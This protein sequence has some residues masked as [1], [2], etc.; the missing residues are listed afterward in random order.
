MALASCE[1][2]LPT[3]PLWPQ[4]RAKTPGQP[5]HFDYCLLPYTPE[6]TTEADL[7]SVNLLRWSWQ[8][9]GVLAEGEALIERLRNALGPNQVVWGIKHRHG[10][11]DAASWEL[12]FY[13]RPHN[14][15]DYTL[16]HVAEIFAPIRVSGAIPPFWRWLMFS[17]E[18][19]V[20]QLRGEAPC[21]ANV[22]VETSGLSYKLRDD[23][24]PELENHYLFRDPQSGIDDILTRLQASVHVRP[25]P[26][27]LA[28]LLPP[29]LMPCLHVCV[30]NKRYAD[31]VYWSRVDIH[32]LQ[33]FLDLHAWPTG[34][35]AYI[36]QHAAQLTHLKWDLGADFQQNH[37]TTGSGLTFTKSGIYGSF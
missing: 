2:A 21:T 29:R 30:A 20:H 32:Q 17:I 31:A 13:R 23:A 18:L 36:R 15:P 14:P 6:T 34:L 5:T 26:L 19:D 33:F 11:P 28:Q 10:Q 9:H 1:S 4:A 8:A 25:H 27:T 35:R 3:L 12:Y 37:E 16:A 22:Y 24:P 7:A